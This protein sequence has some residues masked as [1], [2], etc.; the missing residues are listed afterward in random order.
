MKI[1]DVDPFDQL[2]AEAFSDLCRRHDPLLAGEV[3]LTDSARAE[4][5]DVARIFDIDPE[6][7]SD[8]ALWRAVRSK[9]TEQSA[10]CD[11]GAGG[12]SLPPRIF[13]PAG[14]G[15]RLRAFIPLRILVVE[16]DPDIA[17]EVVDALVE[18]GHE[19]V[20]LT[21][22]AEVA[23]NIA[24]QCPC[25]LAILDVR[26]AGPQ[27]G[28]ELAAML[29]QSRGVPVLFLSGAQN[30]HLVMMEGVLGFIGKPFRRSTLLA[31][32]EVAGRVVRRQHATPA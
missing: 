23:A 11:M 30:E 19:V 5:S 22:R 13:I 4:L 29:R 6:A 27:D 21:D 9:L 32:V 14:E 18:C 31:A 26:L 16:D 1:S 2:R 7:K 24:A 3:A 17:D 10:G 20:G 15:P 25:D 12:A 8:R 28:V